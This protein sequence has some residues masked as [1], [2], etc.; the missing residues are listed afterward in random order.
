MPEVNVQLDGFADERGDAAYNQHLSEKRV[1][2]VKDVLVANGVPAARIKVAAHGESPAPDAS[3]DSYALER[4]VSL[5]LF[6][7]DQR[8]FAATP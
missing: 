6:V 4:K 3:V 5:T 8:S 2:H 7:E 1:A